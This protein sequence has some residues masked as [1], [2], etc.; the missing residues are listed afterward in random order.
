[1]KICEKCGVEIDTKTNRAKWSDGYW[2]WLCKD[3][4]AKMQAVFRKY[5]REKKQ[6][7][8]GQPF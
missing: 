6:K 7:E 8:T 3:C 5:E 4:M 2:A 1:M